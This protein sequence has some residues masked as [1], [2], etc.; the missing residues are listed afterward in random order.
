[1]FDFCF[2]YILP[3]A[4]DHYVYYTVN[5]VIEVGLFQECVCALDDFA[6]PFI[7]SVLA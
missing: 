2:A 3:F 4:V 7:L 5:D 6:I 1:M